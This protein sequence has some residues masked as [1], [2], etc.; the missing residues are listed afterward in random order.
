V[1]ELENA[2]QA[3]SALQPVAGPWAKWLFGLGL[4][5]T[6]LLAVPALAGSSAYAIAEGMRWRASLEEKPKLAAKFYLVLTLSVLVAL[7]LVW[8]K[9]PAVRMLFFASILNGVLAP[10]MVFVV[11]LYS[12]RPSVMGDQAIEIWPEKVS[13]KIQFPSS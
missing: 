8:L 6:G 9:V 13:S 2:E 1:V 4:V 11:V 5:G 7:S 3:A 10:L 12:M